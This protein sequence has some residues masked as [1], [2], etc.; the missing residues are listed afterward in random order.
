MTIFRS[1]FAAFLLS[2][3]VFHAQAQDDGPRCSTTEYMKERLAQNPSLAKDMERNE[4]ALQQWLSKHKT[5]E[6]RGVVTIPVVVHLV[7]NPAINMQLSD[8]QVK[9]QIDVLNEDYR[10]QNADQYKTPSDFLG[11]AADCELQFCLAKRDPAG[12][13]TTGILREPYPNVDAWYMG[14]FDPYK[15]TNWPREQYL[16]I[17]VVKL[18]HYPNEAAPLGY[19]TFPSVTDF[20]DGVVVT[21]TAFG[22]I[23][24]LKSKYNRG[25]TATHE[26]GHW[27][28]LIHVW[29]DDSG[30]NGTD[31][32][33]DT[34]N[35]ADSNVGCPTHPHV[36]CSN[37][38]DMFM[39]YLDYVHD[40]CMNIFTNDQKARMLGT[41][42]TQRPGILSSSGCNNPTA[43]DYDLEVTSIINPSMNVDRRYLN[44]LV[45]VSN[46]GVHS[47]TGFTLYYQFYDQELHSLD[48]NSTLAAGTSE[49]LTLPQIKDSV[50]YNFF[51][52]YAKN[53][54]GASGLVVESDTVNNFATRSFY[55][56]DSANQQPNG[57][58][59]Q[60]DLGNSSF[61]LL[62]DQL[63]YNHFDLTVFN[64]LGQRIDVGYHDT[65]LNKVNVDLKNAVPGVYF[66]RVMNGGKKLSTS[67][68][69]L[70]SQ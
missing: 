9:S 23:G 29:G 3:T 65:E 8:W 16:N 35:Q 49:V 53:T 42:D 51:I 52:A 66:V 64:L 57:M 67:V 10:R 43:Y 68:L 46:P 18:S 60:Y 4:D 20:T 70:P 5:A 62:F 55:V 47:I 17:W 38:G 14:T 2:V 41:L 11:A 30:C 26:V 63:V 37:N 40:S 59:A 32:C 34:P 50:G 56:T 28:N 6:T 54:A 25:R 44:P 36:S 19:T 15:T 7:Y 58:K 39:N 31:Y 1:A 22:R 45:R 69:K 24:E 13:A 27:L 61:D 33:E 48:Y 21:D 12:N